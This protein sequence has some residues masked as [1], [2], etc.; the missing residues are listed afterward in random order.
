MIWFFYLFLL[1]LIIHSQ[2]LSLY[3]GGYRFMQNVYPS[4]ALL[5]E[6]FKTQV[7]NRNQQMQAKSSSSQYVGYSRPVTASS[8]R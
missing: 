1:S 7:S 2:P 3:P 5:I 4:I 6:G 8:Q